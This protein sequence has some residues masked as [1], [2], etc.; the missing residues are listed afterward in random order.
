MLVCGS[1]V[2]LFWLVRARLQ[3]ETAA[4]YDSPDGQAAARESAN[5]SFHSLVKYG[6]CEKL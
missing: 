6:Q 4:P 1:P 3:P 5:D 2:A